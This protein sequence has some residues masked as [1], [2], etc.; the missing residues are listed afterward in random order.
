[1]QSGARRQ[2]VCFPTERRALVLDWA[3]RWA[4]AEGGP[5][6]VSSHVI[7]RESS[8]RGVRAEPKFCESQKMG[9]LIPLAEGPK[10]DARW[11]VR[12]L[13]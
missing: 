4:R 11:V 13:L 10:A 6:G 9:G 2:S 1:M 5:C 8:A 12:Q 7:E 3:K